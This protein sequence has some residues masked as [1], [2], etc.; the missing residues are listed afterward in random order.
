MEIKTIQLDEDYPNVVAYFPIDMREIKDVKEYSKKVTVQMT[1]SDFN[2]II[3][4]LNSDAKSLLSMNK[5]SFNKTG[6]KRQNKKPALK[7]TVL[8]IE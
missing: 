7:I 8:A 4:A 5:A 3:A 1:V 6:K 2:T